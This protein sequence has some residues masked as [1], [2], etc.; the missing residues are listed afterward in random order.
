M[1][2]QN[3]NREKHLEWLNKNNCKIK[4]FNLE[5]TKKHDEYI[6]NHKTEVLYHISDIEIEINYQECIFIIFR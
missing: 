3:K 4:P 6:K 5:T 2:I 1:I